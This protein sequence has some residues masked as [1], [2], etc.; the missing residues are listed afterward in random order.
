M[1]RY[2][3][4]ILGTALAGALRALVFCL[5]FLISWWMICSLSKYNF[6]IHGP[7]D[8][9]ISLIPISLN[10]NALLV[11]DFTI[12]NTNLGSQDVRSGGI[13]PCHVIALP[14]YI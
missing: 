6:F 2:T 3:M 10:K 12:V 14:S 11:C 4:A 13:D 9:I 5:G 7:R 1:D 8:S